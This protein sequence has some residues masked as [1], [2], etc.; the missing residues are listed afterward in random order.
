MLKITDLKFS[1]PDSNFNLQIEN[2][3]LDPGKS[4]ALIGSSGCGKTTLLNL[5]SGIE[6]PSHGKVEINNKEI[7]G[8]SASIRRKWRAEN[9]GFVFQDFRLVEYLNLLDNILLPFKLFKTE[10]K[11][12][13]VRQRLQHMASEFGIEHLL[14]KYPDKV[15]Q[16]EKQRCA[17]ARSIILKPGL[18]LGDEV[19]GNLDPENKRLVMQILLDYIEKEKAMLVLSSHDHDLLSSFDKVFDFNDP[20]K[21]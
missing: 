20:S 5:I 4:L 19:T 7:S 21:A 11:E 2:L 18:I 12:S 10:L 17:I 14:K 1:Y 16:G 3:S 9:V 8:E 6:V 13:E 15:S